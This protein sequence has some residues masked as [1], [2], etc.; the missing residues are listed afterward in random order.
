MI[1]IEQLVE[2][3]RRGDALAWEALVR[4]TQGRV[5]GMALHYLKSTEDA[6]DAAQE[7]FV[8]VWTRL[9]RFDG[10]DFLPWLL[11]L[12]RNACIDR[13]RSIRS[14]PPGQDV[15][16][17]DAALAD[18]ADDAERST[19]RESERRLLRR[20]IDALTGPSREIVELKELEGLAFPEIA[21]ALGLPVGTVKS[22]AHRARL[23]LARKVLEL[24]PSYGKEG[25][26]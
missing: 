2:G 6:R 15:D 23:E 1:S 26:R 17:E 9:H 13:V 21:K 4:R 20:A 14:R 25:T 18:R 8:K 22:R 16:A 7:V 10:G 3:C 11:R 5:Y 12:T 24:D 19:L